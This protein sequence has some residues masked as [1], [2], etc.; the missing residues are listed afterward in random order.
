MRS[1]K[2]A[3]ELHIVHALITEVRRV[4]IETEARMIFHRFERALGGGDVEG[5]FRRMHLEREVDVFLFEHVED[6]QPAFGEIGKAFVQKILVRRRKGVKRVPDGRAGEAVDD[7]GKSS[8]PL[9]PGRALKNFRA[10]SAVAFIFSAARWRTPSGL[11]SPQT[12]AGRMAWCR[13]S[14]KSHT[15]WPTRCVE[16]AKQVRPCFWSSAHF[17]LHVIGFGER[18][19]HFKVVAPAGEFHAVVAHGFDLGRE[20]GERKIGPLAGEE[21]DGS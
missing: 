14:I 3:D 10:A 9:R 6:R 15:A 4:V 2:F 8:P 20:F 18:A 13:S 16:M 7:G 12:S 5:D 21:C 11:P 19:V 1:P 17:F